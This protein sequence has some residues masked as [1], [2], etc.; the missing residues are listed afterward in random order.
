MLTILT[1]VGVGIVTGMTLSDVDSAGL[2][3][4]FQ[5]PRFDTVV[6]TYSVMHSGRFCIVVSV[7]DDR[8]FTIGGK[9]LE[10]RPT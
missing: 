2:T 5:V 10:C 8:T 9:V 4:Q 1:V 3:P 7:R 6:L